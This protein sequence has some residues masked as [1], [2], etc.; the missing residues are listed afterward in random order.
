M[1]AEEMFAKVHHK[2]HGLCATSFVITT[3]MWLRE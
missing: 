3:A 1:R 2:V